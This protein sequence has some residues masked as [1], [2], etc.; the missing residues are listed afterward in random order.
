MKKIIDFIHDLKFSDIPLNSQ[1]MAETCVLDL[2]GVGLAGTSTKLSSVICNHAIE[3]YNSDKYQTR[4]LFDGRYCSAAGA[5]LAGGMTIDS[6]DAHD[7]FN[8]AK[9][10][11]GCGVFPSAIAFADISNSFGGHSFLTDMI[12]G[13][14]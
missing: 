4:I 7:G 13:Y 10:H 2:I 8:G 6:I 1:K 5:A 9:G 12:I 14:E 11:V 3:M